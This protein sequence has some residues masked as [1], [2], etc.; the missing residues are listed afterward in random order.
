[1]GNTHWVW[2]R[3]DAS[4]EHYLRILILQLA[5]VQKNTI[6]V[7]LVELLLAGLPFFLG[8]LPV[9]DQQITVQPRT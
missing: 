5:S 3:I 8:L 6:G 9:G 7:L 4:E 2:L 1:M